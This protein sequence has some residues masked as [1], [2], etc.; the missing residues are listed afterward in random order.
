MSRKKYHPAI[1]D[2]AQYCKAL[3]YFEKHKPIPNEKYLRKKNPDWKFKPLIKDNDYAIVSYEK[4]RIVFVFQGSNDIRDWCNNFI[5]K[6]VDNDRFDIDGV[7]KGFHKSALKFKDDVIRICS[8]Y[9]D[10]HEILF[11][12]HSRAVPLAAINAY[13][14][15]K[16]LGLSVSV[17]GFG[18][19]RFASAAFRDEYRKLP[20][21]F[22]ECIIKRDPVPKLPF[23]KL[24][25]KRVGHVKYLKNKWWYFMP[26]PGIGFRV[27][28]D[29]YDNI[30][31]RS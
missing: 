2:A 11:A 23:K 22:T 28:T 14:V 31:G 17:I 16:K 8:E 27:H 4:D 6:K 7:H 15:A 30:I 18:G 21:H 24:G 26:V 1:V 3:D 12:C 5:F 20:I 10:S 25:Y 29:Y 9:G 13:I 19:P